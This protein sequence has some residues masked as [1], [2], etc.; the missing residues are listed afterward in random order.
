MKRATLV[1]VAMVAVLLPIAA[2]GTA[3]GASHNGYTYTVELRNL[4]G[5]QY[6]TP[7]N[8]AAHTMAADVFS[9]GDEASSALQQLAENGNNFGMAAA[10][11]AAVDDQGLGVSGN[12]G[13]PVGPGQTSTWEFTTTADRLSVVSMVICTNDGFAGLD[14]R[15]LPTHA[16]ATKTYRLHAYDAGTEINTEAR[17]DL[18]PAPFCG[19]PGGTGTTNPDLAENGDIGHHRGILGTGDLDDSFDWSGPIVEMV[20]TRTN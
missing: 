14:S 4:T 9:L 5:G 3:A 16:G 19:G 8:W 10:I 11:E 15:K 1:I 7:P 20:V 13:G 12:P 18:V 2:F 17:D 6:L